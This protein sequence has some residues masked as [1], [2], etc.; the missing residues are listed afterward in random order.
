MK[1]L[2]TALSSIM[3]LMFCASVYTQ[4]ELM[5]LVTGS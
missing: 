4:Q 1:Y 2:G 3:L 5:G